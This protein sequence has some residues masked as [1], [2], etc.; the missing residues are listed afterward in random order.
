[1]EKGNPLRVEGLTPDELGGSE[2]VV[3]PRREFCFA[4]GLHEAQRNLLEDVLRADRP[5]TVRK[6]GFERLLDE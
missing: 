2:A 4:R 1:M 5:E 6:V 3:C